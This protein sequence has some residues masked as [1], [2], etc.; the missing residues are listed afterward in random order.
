MDAGGNERIK[1]KVAPNGA[2]EID[3]LDA[4][5]EVVKAIRAQDSSPQKLAI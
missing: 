5:G 4:N 1:M 2:A 3:F